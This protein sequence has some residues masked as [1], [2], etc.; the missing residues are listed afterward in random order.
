MSVI[1]FRPQRCNLQKCFRLTLF[2]AK[3]AGPLLQSNVIVLVSITHLEEGGGAVLH[4]NERGTQRGQLSVGQ[5]AETQSH[6]CN[7]TST[8]YFWK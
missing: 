5:E 6:I 2:N 4:G 3:A 7:E 8:F 1:I